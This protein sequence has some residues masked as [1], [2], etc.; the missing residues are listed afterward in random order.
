MLESTLIH[1]IFIR[2]QERYTQDELRNVLLCSE[3]EIIKII[4]TLKSYGIL[5]AV[6]NTELQRNKDLSDL[7]ENDEVISD[8]ERNDK[9]HL[10]VFTFVGVLALAGKIIKCYPK[11]ITENDKPINELKQVLKVLEKYNNSKEQIIK[12][13]VEGSDDSSFNLLAM[14]MFFLNDYF[15]NGTYENTQN[16]IETNGLGEILWDKTINETFALLSSGNP[17]YFDLQTRKR[18]VDDLDYFKRLHE[19]ILTTVSTELKN[20]QLNELFDLSEVYLSDEKLPDFG[21]DEYILYKIEKEL[22]VQYTTRKQILLKAMYAYIKNKNSIYNENAISLIGTNNFNLVWEEICKVTLDNHLEATINS[23]EEVKQND[24]YNKQKLIDLIEKPKWTIVNMCAEKTLIPDIITISNKCFYIFDAKYYRPVFKTNT[25]PTSQPG[26]D[27]IT[28]QYLYQ[29][30]YSDFIEEQKFNVKN[31]FLLPTEND[32]HVVI[33]SGEVTLDMF[34][35]LKLVDIDVKFISA[36]HIYEL[37]LKNNT[38]TL[39]KEIYPI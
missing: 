23:I 8:V 34:A 5:K 13:F 32:E 28:K 39:L 11:Y 7:E 25:P 2:E 18:K 27:S 26:I 16:I 24:K 35:K 3:D 38:T 6:P 30:A 12:M 1:S 37:Y 33:N 4:K 31:C 10:Y 22:N 14:Y 29:L 9:N 36:T 19:C 20:A 17:I 21:E 15:E